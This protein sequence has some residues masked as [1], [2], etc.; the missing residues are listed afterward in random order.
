MSWPSIE[1]GREFKSPTISLV[2]RNLEVLF[3][4]RI[5]QELVSAK[6]EVIEGT[7][8]RALVREKLKKEE[9]RKLKF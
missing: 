6:T 2:Q 8:E 4:S 1:K 7:E 3:E 9:K 5:K